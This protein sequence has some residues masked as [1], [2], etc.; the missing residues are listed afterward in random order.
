MTEKTL[1]QIEWEAR[2]SFYKKEGYHPSFQT[3]WEDLSGDQKDAMEAGAKAV[4]LAVIE[5]CAKV[6]D[7]WGEGKWKVKPK[8]RVRF[9]VYDMQASVNTTG[10]G[11][12]EDIR[13]LA[14]ASGESD[15]TINVVDLVA[16]LGER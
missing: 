13:A 3:E 1:G 16:K 15:Q 8:G 4:R 5:E 9:S 7:Y 12:A 6:A 2:I 11:I 14:S 10:R